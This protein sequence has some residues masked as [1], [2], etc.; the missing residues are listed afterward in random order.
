[1]TTLWPWDFAQRTAARTT[2][3][4]YPFPRSVGSVYMDM[5]YGARLAR[6]HGRGGKGMSQRAPLAGT[7][8]RPAST[9]NTTY[10]PARIS[11]RAHRR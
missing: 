6:V 7:R 4:A 5:R 1:M 11:A 10:R 2:I 3:V 9:R 8:P